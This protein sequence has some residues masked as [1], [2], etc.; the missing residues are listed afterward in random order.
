MT[1]AGQ[2]AGGGRSVPSAVP[3]QGPSDLSAAVARHRARE[4]GPTQPPGVP[5]GG[6]PATAGADPD[7]P[8]GVTPGQQ[9][10]DAPVAPGGPGAFGQGPACG[11][12]GY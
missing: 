9:W 11:T 5:A 1:P 7:G 3:S 8:S 2:A 12:G 6:W 10:A 4:A